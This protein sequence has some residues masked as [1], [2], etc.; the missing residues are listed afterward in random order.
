MNVP[1][2]PATYQDIPRPKDRLPI[3]GDALHLDTD[4][5]TRSLM[6]LADQLGPIYSFVAPG[7]DV[8]VVSGGDIV[9]EC[10]DETRFEKNN[11]PE[12]VTMREVVGDA[13][14]S[15]WTQ[16]PSWKKAHNILLPAFAPQAIKGYTQ[17]MAD[18]ADQLVM[19]WARLNP[20]DPVDISTDMTKLTF[21]TICLVCF[22]YRPGSF[23]RHDMPPIV[24]AL[25]EAIAECVNRP[26]RLP[27]QDVYE[28]I[29]GRRRYK[30]NV[31]FLNN[32]ADTIIEER[33]R[34]ADVGKNGDVLDL[35]LT[36]PDKDSGQKL[37][38]LS[39]R[40]Q[41]LTFL[42][43]G[44]DTT[45]G[46]LMWTVYYLLKNPDVLAKC[47]AEV[48]EVFG[49]DLSVLP[50]ETQIS[51]LHYLMQCMKE[52]LRLWPVGAGF[53]VR[54]LADEV[55]AG[56]YRIKKG[57]AILILT[58]QLQRDPSIF[59]EP[60]TY[61]PNRFTADLEASRPAWAW[62]PFGSGQRACIGR[63]FSFHE[64]QLLLGL[65]LQRFK[66]LDSFDYQLDIKDFFSIKPNN[67]TITIA[68]REGRDEAVITGLRAAVTTEA[69]V[70]A[71]APK[72]VVSD[73]GSGNPV[74]VLHGSNLGTSERIANE[75]AEDARA[76]GFA[77]SQGPLDD[78]VHALPQE[79]LVVICTS[80]YNG[81]PP[82][83]AVKFHQWLGSGLGP[84]ALAGV[85]YTVFG[86]GDRVWASTFQKV[87]A[88]I[89]ERL[90]AAGATRFSPRGFAD[91]SDDFDGMFRDWY[92]CFWSQAADALGLAPQAEVVTDMNRYE[93]AS[94][95]QRLHSSFFSSLSATPFRMVE[96]RELLTRVL[97]RGG[98]GQSTRHIEFEIPQGA[99]YRTGDH[100][101]LLPRNAAELVGRAAALAE[102]DLDELVMIHANTGAPS[103]LPLATPFVVS[104]LLA[105]RVELQAPLT[106]AQ[107]RT[108][109]EFA[110]DPD[111]Q[112]QLASL[113]A[114]GDENITR[115][116]EEILFKRVS[117][118][119]MVQRY[120][121]I[122]VPLNTCLDLLP[123]LAPRY[124]SI[125]SSPSVSPSRC[126]ITVGVLQAPARNGHGAYLGTSSNFLARTQPGAVVPGFIRPPGLPFDVP[127]DP[128]TPMIMIATGTGLS[129]FRGFLQERNAQGAN[130]KL[131][132]SLL[133]YGCRLPDSDF[134][135]ED[136]IR[137]FEADGIVTIVPAYSRIKDGSRVQD[138]VR[139]HAEEILEL[140]ARG[141]VTYVCGGAGTVA[142]A[143][144]DAFAEIYQH[145]AEVSPEEGV[146]WLEEQRAANRYLED[147]WA[148]H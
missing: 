17:K 72:R 46:M 42:A 1:G 51:K 143:L 89:D 71:P 138:A 19:K 12:L 116:R 99:T 6:D 109:A 10:L 35:M 75:I 113:A 36:Q 147:V 61:D 133:I 105:A 136:E 26:S 83:N 93:I 91:A 141:G 145:S 117:L 64:S 85:T 59:P 44:Y 8:I 18:I 87:P 11:S 115:Y 77:V 106:R 80:S 32:V 95:G 131:G 88:E 90:E 2:V 60:E 20:G 48:D 139:A 5:P 134:I 81:N 121:S 15:A 16:E 34:S 124:Y 108:L 78:Y 144:R 4:H 22:S 132:P 63:H 3:L 65:I 41:M 130:A 101:A 38:R 62:M 53:Q 119:D 56:K 148:A 104:E 14:F 110:T 120:R 31:S 122:D 94:T 73:Y 68:P 47:Y 84:S 24:T 37:D 74:L 27:G 23:Y 112:A 135:Y 97:E 125:S 21:D 52:A 96:N 140:I 128:A 82:D 118:L 103:H 86:A 142:P 111:E 39:I 107:L 9:D 55:L 29:K 92:A 7:Q 66:L 79:G 57:Q 98:S 40:Q 25:E 114:D 123:G 69:H 50:T 58:P 13:I 28:A 33:I 146:A 137:Q 76:R 45:S 54:A 129:P 49:D 43:A 30:E 70:E 102:L 67:L 127:E 100:I 126:S